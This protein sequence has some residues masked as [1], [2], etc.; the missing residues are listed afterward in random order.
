MNRL[1]NVPAQPGVYA[2]IGVHGAENYGYV[3]Y[4]ANLRHRA[5]VWDYNFSQRAKNP[6]HKMPVRNIPDFIPEDAWTFVAWESD[7]PVLADEVREHLK[8]RGVKL[9]NDKTRIHE[10]VN[11]NGK[12]ATFA[13]HCRD[14]NINYSRAYARLKKGKPLEQV[15]ALPGMQKS[16]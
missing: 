13:E 6:A 15:F 9:L 16:T 2:L 4:C 10:M 7:K 5:A 3:G 14:H 8:A 11:Y 1:G 12:T